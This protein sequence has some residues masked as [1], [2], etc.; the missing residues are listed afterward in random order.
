MINHKNEKTSTEKLKDFIANDKER[1]RR[2][3]IQNI[4]EDL[5][6]NEIKKIKDYESMIEEKI[7]NMKR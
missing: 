6:R 1:K 7:L 2:I 4:E 5:K 3:L